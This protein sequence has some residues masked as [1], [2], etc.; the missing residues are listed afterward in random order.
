MRRLR[1]D[2]NRVLG[3]ASLSVSFLGAP[4]NQQME[5]R[6]RL[7]T[8]ASLHWLFG[9]A[10]LIRAV[11]SL[12]DIIENSLTVEFRLIGRGFVPKELSRD[13]GKECTEYELG[14]DKKLT[15]WILSKT[16]TGNIDIKS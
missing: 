12:I 16:N 3:S 10:A 8:G 7:I 5:L 11:N 1:P 14:D 13:L 2:F 6:T 15:F 4:Q 9:C